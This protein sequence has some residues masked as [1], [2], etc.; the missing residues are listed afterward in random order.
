VDAITH[1]LPD[2]H[3]FGTA[4]ETHAFTSLAAD[5]DAMVKELVAIQPPTT[6]L[7]LH[8][9]LVRDARTIRNGLTQ[10]A[11]ASQAKDAGAADAPLAEIS[12]ALG[13]MR[14]TVNV[15][16]AKLNSGG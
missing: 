1:G 16:D 3:S 9:D 7:L 10:V 11:A 5:V 13:D 12:A 14:A 4:S 2:P 15:I 8:Q 6:V